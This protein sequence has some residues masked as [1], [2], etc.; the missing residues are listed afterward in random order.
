MLGKS[1]PNPLLLRL[2][3]RET[4][5]GERRLASGGTFAN[6]GDGETRSGTDQLLVDHPA[7]VDAGSTLG[8]GEVVDMV[9]VIAEL[10]HALAQ[11]LH[12][13]RRNKGQYTL[14]DVS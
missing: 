12:T 1:C 9:V 4:P 10:V 7:P 13:E 11:L 5:R 6:R 8:P 14:A 2:A 3:C